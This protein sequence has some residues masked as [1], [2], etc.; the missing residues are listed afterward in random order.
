MP[1]PAYSLDAYATYWE[2]VDP[3]PDT[4]SPVVEPE[5]QTPT[6]DAYAQFA[7]LAD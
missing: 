4:P 5:P 1:T 7:A 3:T 6:S 2:T